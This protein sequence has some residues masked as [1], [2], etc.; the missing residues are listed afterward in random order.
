MKLLLA[1]VEKT[2]S[3]WNWIG[4]LHKS[5]Y[6]W[7]TSSGKTQLAHRLAYKIFKGI[8]P[9]ELCVCHSCDNKRC[10]NPDHLWL[11]SQAENIKDR[12]SKGRQVSPSGEK[13]RFRL[14]PESVPK[15]SAHPLAKLTE[16]QVLAIKS[17]YSLG[18]SVRV[19]AKEY[20]VNVPAVYKLLNGKTWR[21]LV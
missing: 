18:W 9:Q 6:G 4:C 7:V 3:C 19:L 16:P 12:D 11:G 21:H 14:Y 10:V 5:G 17:R 2:D 13:H 15:G 1:K 8:I 20:G